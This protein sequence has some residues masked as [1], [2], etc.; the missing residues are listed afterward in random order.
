MVED[1]MTGE[2]I[3]RRYSSGCIPW[4][5]FCGH[6]TEDR[7][8]RLNAS[9]GKI[10]HHLLKSCFPGAYDD[11]RKFARARGLSQWHPATQRNFWRNEHRRNNDKCRVHRGRVVAV[12]KING[13]DLSLVTVMPDGPGEPDAN[14]YRAVNVHH[15]PLEEGDIVYVHKYV[16]AE[17]DQVAHQCATSFLRDGALS[18]FQ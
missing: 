14:P 16:V 4:M 12:I 18:L 10:S 2:E 6:I 9:K 5:I 8:R 1:D 15:L 7:L 13:T 3:F 11:S 17:T